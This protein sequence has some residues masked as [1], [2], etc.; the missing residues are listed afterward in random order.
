MLYNFVQLV[1]LSFTG[2]QGK[3][4]VLQFKGF[5]AV[6]LSQLSSWREFGKGNYS[7]FQVRKKA[8]SERR[9]KQHRELIK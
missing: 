8:I 1:A 3:C 4:V 6:W 7:Q 5:C 9:R 2:Q